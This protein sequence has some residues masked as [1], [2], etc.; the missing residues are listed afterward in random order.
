ML[1]K[2][3][4][5]LTEKQNS[6]EK[7]GNNMEDLQMGIKLLSTHKKKRATKHFIYQSEAN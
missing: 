5:N 4:N 2:G 3:I 6:E 1:Q 7:W